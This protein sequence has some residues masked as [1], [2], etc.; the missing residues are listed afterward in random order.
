[1]GT[2]AKN[3]LNFKIFDVTNWITHNY[4]THAARF[5]KE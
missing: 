5:L 1:M 2:L 3:G 4:N